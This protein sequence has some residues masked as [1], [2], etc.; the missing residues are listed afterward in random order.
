MSFGS[1]EIRQRYGLYA[2][3][4]TMPA[5]SQNRRAQTIHIWTTSVIRTLCWRLWFS[6][7]DII[8][9]HLL[10]NSVQMIFQRA[11][12]R[13]ISLWLADQGLLM[14]SVTEYVSR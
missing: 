14:T 2:H 5:S 9:R 4:V 12:Q 13:P 3:S 10:K 11:T 6:Y 1:P 7:P 8:R